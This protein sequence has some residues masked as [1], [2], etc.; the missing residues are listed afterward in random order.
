[1]K[2]LEK[3]DYEEPCCPFELPGRIDTVPLCRILQKLDEHLNGEHYAAARTH[4]E[5]WLQEAD[6]SRDRRGKLSLLN[7]MIGLCRKCGWEEQGLAAADEALALID[8]LELGESVTCGTTL[9]NAATALKAFGRAGEA[10]PLY[11]RARGLYE[12]LLEPDDA[13]LGS[14]FNN[15]AL[16]EAELGLFEEAREHYQKALV[17]M[18]RAENGALEQAI[19]YC[20][21]ADLAAQSLAEEAQ[22][23]EVGRCLGLAE[24]LLKQES[25]PRDAYYAYVLE[26]CA[27]C[28]GYHGYFAV[29][30]ELEAEA[31]RIRNTQ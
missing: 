11:E 22:E 7:E 24:S 23:A 30:L 9:V 19:S 5:Y 26:K 17:I 21:L 15:E 14:L 27:P 6:E 8:E 4:L 16:A 1:M 29:Q 12:R 25:L 3:S 31:A 20:N 13:R 10:L 2:P 18:A 28:F